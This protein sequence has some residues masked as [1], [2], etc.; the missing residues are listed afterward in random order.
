MNCSQAR[1]TR[2]NQLN[3]ITAG[4]SSRVAGDPAVVRRRKEPETVRIAPAPATTA[5]ALHTS[6]IQTGGRTFIQPKKA[7]NENH[8]RSMSCQT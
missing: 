6:Q 5:M 7:N 1:A 3:R 4:W 2:T 8:T